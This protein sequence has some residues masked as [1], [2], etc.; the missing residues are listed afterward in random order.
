MAGCGDH[1]P[2]DLPGK[3]ED[4]SN[5]RGLALKWDNLDAIRQR[6][7]DGYNLVIH[8]DEKLKKATNQEVEKTTMNVKANYFV[9]APVCQMMFANGLVNIG[10]LEQEVKQLYSMYNVLANEKTVGKQAWAIR[11]LI[12]VLKQSTKADKNDRTKPK[13]CPKDSL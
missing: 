8:Y 1:S 6:M 12:S 13:R 4:K 10:G 11:H 3:V 5:G 9:L 2:K 7:R